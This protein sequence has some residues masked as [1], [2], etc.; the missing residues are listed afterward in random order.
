MTRTTRLLQVLSWVGVLSG[1]AAP[2]TAPEPA[3]RTVA[4]DSFW[5]LG[6][7]VELDYEVA[8]DEWLFGGDIRLTPEER[9]S[10]AWSE[11]GKKALPAVKEGGSLKSHLWPNAVIPYVISKSVST[12]GRVRDAMDVWE[13]KTAIRFVKR[14]SQKAYLEVL[15]SKTVDVCNSQPGYSGDKRELRLKPAGA[16][17]LGVLVHELG[18]T[19]GFMHEH[20]RSDRNQYVKIYPECVPQDSKS[21]SVFSSGVFE[22]G[23]YDIVST[24]HYKSTTLSTCAYPKSSIKKKNG[25][26]LGH[27]WETLSA[28]D[29]AATAK[30]YGAPAGDQDTDGVPDSSDNCPKD[31]NASQLDTDG[32]KVGDVCDTDDDGDGV[33]D[34][35]DNC[36]KNP[37]PSQLDTDGD[38]KGDSCDGDDDGDGVAD[39]KDDCPKVANANQLDA[40]Q[41]GKGDVCDDD[42]DGDG[43]PD[44]TDNCPTQSNPSQADGNGDGVGDACSSDGDGDGVADGS[45]NC[46]SLENP[47]QANLD[48]DEEG[49]ACDDD[50]DQDGVADANDN[51][52][53]LANADQ[54]DEDQDQ[55]GDACQGDSD[56]DGV[57]DPLDNCPSVPNPDQ[58]DSD[59]DGTGDAC[60]DS[61][62]DGITDDDDNCPKAANP[63]QADADGDAAGDACDADGD[64]PPGP[65]GDPDLGAGDGGADAIGGCVVSSPNS[66]VPVSAWS[67]GVLAALAL[68]ARRRPRTRA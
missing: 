23:P 68:A 18:H 29:V 35:Q 7:P 8:G 54:K 16:C 52:P 12:P 27:D 66:T 46:P 60:P 14:T 2:E 40:D 11:P 41:D 57:N 6:Q 10:G 15:E 55:V 45:D 9:V 38:G 19:I 61:D 50:D 25:G 39:S 30:M 22:F 31:A 24:M 43:V 4:R 47:D 28:G 58:F 53:T 1:C 56:E 20:Q 13:K 59:G 36:D 63:D 32:D 49:D 26:W 37:N 65:P 42:D 21:F 33:A 44:A 5:L 17:N 34:A 64:T 3:P 62:H 51:C 67:L 48:Q